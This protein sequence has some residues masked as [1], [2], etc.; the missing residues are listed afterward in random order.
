MDPRIADALLRAGIITAEQAEALRH[1][2]AEMGR[3]DWS[4]FVAAET[5]PEDDEPGG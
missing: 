1:E 5:K 2:L 4:G 3:K